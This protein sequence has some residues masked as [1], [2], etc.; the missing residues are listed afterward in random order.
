[1]VFSLAFCLRKSGPGL[2]VF[3]PGA[4]KSLRTGLPCPLMT[5]LCGDLDIEQELD[6]GLVI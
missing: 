4:Q 2:R 6:S 3:R 5:W 1:M